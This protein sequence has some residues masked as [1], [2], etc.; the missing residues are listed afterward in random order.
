VAAISPSWIP[1]SCAQ[2]GQLDHSRLA[3]VEPRPGREA[4]EVDTAGGHVL[5]ELSGRDREALRGELLVQLRVHNV[6][7][8][9]VRRGRVLSDA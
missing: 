1:S 8:A 4:E 5:A 9:E 2:A 3:E 6:D 7:L